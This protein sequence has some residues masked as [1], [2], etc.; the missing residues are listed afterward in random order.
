MV[1]CVTLNFF[2][3][4]QRGGGKTPSCVLS[5]QRYL[6]KHLKCCYVIKVFFSFFHFQRLFLSF[7]KTFSKLLG[8]GSSPGQSCPA[9]CEMRSWGRKLWKA[10]VKLGG[11]FLFHRLASPWECPSMS[12]MG[13]VGNALSTWLNR[14]WNFSANTEVGTNS[15]GRW[16]E[17]LASTH[18]TMLQA[19]RQNLPLISLHLELCFRALGTQTLIRLVVLFCLRLKIE[20]LSSR[21]STRKEN[22]QH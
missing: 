10:S 21:V 16:I 1:V 4:R 17:A 3:L 5:T 12:L 19:Q 14:V 7:L 8:V 11:L 20:V 15:P 13:S 22:S 6:I 9:A 2:F 18:T